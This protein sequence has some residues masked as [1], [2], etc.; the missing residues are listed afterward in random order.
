MNTIYVAFKGTARPDWEQRVVVPEYPTYKPETRERKQ[1]EFLDNYQAGNELPT[2][3]ITTVGIKNETAAYRELTLAEFADE[4]MQITN[5]RIIGVELQ[6]AL[7][8][9]AWSLDTA[10]PVWWWDCYRFGDTAGIQAINL[11]SASGAKAGGITLP[12]WLSLWGYELPQDNLQEQIT[13]I[14]EIAHSMGF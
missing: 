5:T 7:R 8:L 10:P 14:V 6:H 9:C 4:C 12:Q 11:Y 3:L 2:A 13:N 1:K